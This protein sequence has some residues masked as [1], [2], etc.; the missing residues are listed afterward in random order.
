MLYVITKNIYLKIEFALILVTVLLYKKPLH[1]TN[2]I[3]LQSMS[4][5]G[6]QMHM[7]IITINRYSLT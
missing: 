7:S 5:V 4:F 3:I 2:K 1:N 6:N